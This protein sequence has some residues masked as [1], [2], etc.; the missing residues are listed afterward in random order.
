MKMWK[1]IDPRTTREKLKDELKLEETMKSLYNF[2]TDGRERLYRSMN[3]G[4][5]E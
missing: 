5:F 2:F 1:H 3:M 4:C